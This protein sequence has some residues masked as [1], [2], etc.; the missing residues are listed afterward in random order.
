M[1]AQ[2]RKYLMAPATM[3][4]SADHAAVRVGKGHAQ[5]LAEANHLSLRQMAANRDTKG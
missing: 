3:D 1:A 4:G 2:Q 5:G